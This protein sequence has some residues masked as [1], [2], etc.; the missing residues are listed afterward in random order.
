MSKIRVFYDGL[1]LIPAPT[2]SIKKEFIYANDNIIGYTYNI[3][4]NGYAS[5]VNKENN[6]YV[7]NITNTVNALD[8]IHF[9]LHKNGKNLTITCDDTEIFR[10]EGGQLRSFNVEESDNKWVQY[11][12]YSASL[13][14]SNIGYSIGTT[15]SI[16]DDTLSADSFDYL[17][18]LKNYNDSWNFQA[19]EEEVYSF[20]IVPGTASEDFSR[21]NVTY[22]ISATGKHYYDTNGN[23]IPAWVAAK[24]FV[25]QKIYHQILTFKNASPLS[26]YFLP[27]TSYNSNEISGPLLNNALSSTY[28]G[29]TLYPL[30]NN[31]LINNFSIF[32]ESINCTTS[33][34]DGTF[35]AT[36]SC[37]CKKINQTWMPYSIHTFD[38]A[39]D[40]TRD[41][42]EINNTISVNG[43]VTG[44]L[45]TNILA[46]VADGSILVLPNNGS[47]I[48]SD[49]PGDYVTKYFNAL[50]DFNMY[51]A[52]ATHS[53]LQPAYKTALN[54]TY[55]T[56]FS[57]TD[58]ATSC[59]DLTTL[60]DP[61][62]FSINHNYATGSIEYSIE[63]NTN[64]A[65]SRS[66][67][68]ETLT[69]SEEDS[70]PIIA[71]FVIPGR[72]EGP[73]LQFLNTNSNKK[74]S[75]EFKGVTKKGCIVGTP[76]NV[77]F[78]GEGLCK[79]EDYVNIPDVVKQIFLQ[80]ENGALALGSQL[81]TESHNIN[82]SPVTGDYTASKK[83]II[84]PPPLPEE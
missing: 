57:L 68:F 5:S 48:G 32:N 45:E 7:S 13:E 84:C 81:I 19:S 26:F 63:Y 10:A 39:Y 17:V 30:L 60:V 4:I 34:S 9:I 50:R 67:G 47:F 71:E 51:I 64:R 73:I 25:Q 78:Q 52:D 58:L 1:E 3:N 41:F 24:N 49:V 18:K 27:N 76:F 83:Y 59:I 69:I 36:Y 21:F 43:T 38:I 72:E 22:T 79:T 80:T 75:M 40:K 31:N 37:V 2:I 74:I 66:R 82:Y 65:C 23:L 35:S 53:D 55:G 6:N 54:V 8:N 56:L 46:N 70:V 14:F 15:V 42:K 11:T 20:Y 12:K 33:E 61:Q 62:S 77:D 29:A 16:A 44:M 28:T